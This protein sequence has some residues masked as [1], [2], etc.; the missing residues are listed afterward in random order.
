MYP[1]AGLSPGNGAS[2]HM[3]YVDAAVT[4]YYLYFGGK[5]WALERAR[6]IK[7]PLLACLLH[8]IIIYYY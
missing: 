6:T 1:C 4:R 8:V 5:R 3:A 7:L 2:A